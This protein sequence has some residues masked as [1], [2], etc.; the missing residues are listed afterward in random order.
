MEVQS[1]FSG[2]MLGHFRRSELVFSPTFFVYM[3]VQAQSRPPQESRVVLGN[4]R[5]AVARGTWHRFY[6]RR[7]SYLPRKKKRQAFPQEK[8]VKGLPC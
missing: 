5:I 8:T 7:L 4:P 3:E 1:P 2:S 6:V